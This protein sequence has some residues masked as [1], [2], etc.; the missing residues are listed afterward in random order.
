MQEEAGLG[1]SCSMT[2]VQNALLAELQDEI[3]PVETLQDGIPLDDVILHAEILLAGILLED[4]IH[5]VEIL[6]DEIL[7]E[8]VIHRAETHR[9]AAERHTGVH[10]DGLLH[11]VAVIK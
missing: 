4:V 10:P 8:D 1:I 7:L 2:Q 9:D 11:H 3:L 5:R 6:L